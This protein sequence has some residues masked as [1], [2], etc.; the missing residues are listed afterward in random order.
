MLAGEIK[1][2]NIGL[3]VMSELDK[4]VKQSTMLIIL[5]VTIF[6]SLQSAASDNGIEKYHEFVAYESIVSVERGTGEIEKFKVPFI[7]DSVERSGDTLLISGYNHELFVDF[8]PLTING[9]DNFLS[10]VSPAFDAK[11][12][13]TSEVPERLVQEG[14]DPRIRFGVEPAEWVS[15]FP[16]EP[17]DNSFTE[18]SQ[19]IPSPLYASEAGKQI[20][21][22]HE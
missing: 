22:D 20:G 18:A 11:R 1:L 15:D 5:M 19:P 10:V 17:G 13:Q 3:A 8:Y 7:V 2:N 4:S 12:R 21:D 6:I 9:N 14:V 16:V